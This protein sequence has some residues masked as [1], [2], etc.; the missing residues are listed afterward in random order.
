MEKYIENLKL[1]DD[2]ETGIESILRSLKE[3][4]FNITDEININWPNNPE[5]TF[6]VIW[7]GWQRLL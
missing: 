2:V 6:K 5:K 3:N 7:Y 4:K 1:E